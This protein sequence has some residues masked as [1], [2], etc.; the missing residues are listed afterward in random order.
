MWVC[1]RQVPLPSEPCAST[2]MCLIGLVT[3]SAPQNLLL[4][5][6][7]QYASSIMVLGILKQNIACCIDVIATSHVCPTC[8]MPTQVYL[9]QVSDGTCISTVHPH[10]TPQN[11]FVW[12][13]GLKFPCT[14]S[15]HSLSLPQ[16][17]APSFVTFT[18]HPHGPSCINYRSVHRNSPGKITPGTSWISS[19]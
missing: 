7:F 1:P 3:S 14:L 2:C 15:S 12:P 10:C 18:P 4:C 13:I 16:Q 11:S 6:V 5:L 9:E 8:C 17:F 19:N